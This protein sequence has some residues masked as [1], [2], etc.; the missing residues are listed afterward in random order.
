MIQGRCHRKDSLPR[1]VAPHT[2]R[3]EYQTPFDPTKLGHDFYQQTLPERA[4]RRNGRRARSGTL[5]RPGDS[6]EGA[7]EKVPEKHQQVHGNNLSPRV[8][9][10]FNY[11]IDNSVG[12]RVFNS[13]FGGN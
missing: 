7:Q 9:W 1:L 6:S 10:R 12:K 2:A 4:A 8:G 3:N 13:S 5:D 11:L